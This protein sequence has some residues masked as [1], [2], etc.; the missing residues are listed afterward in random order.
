MKRDGMLPCIMF[1]FSRS[2]CK[3]VPMHIVDT[4][5]SSFSATAMINP[6]NEARTR[7]RRETKASRR[8][9]GKTKKEGKAKKR[10]TEDEDEEDMEG[11]SKEIFM[12][13]FS[14]VFFS[15]RE[16]DCNQVLISKLP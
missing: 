14:Q 11:E 13:F 3:H 4:I 9:G 7:E 5:D 12:E 15:L 2:L 1:F 6:F 10:P 8:E 16:Y